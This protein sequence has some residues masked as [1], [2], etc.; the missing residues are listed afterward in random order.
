[1][2]AVVKLEKTIKRIRVIEQDFHK[3]SKRLKKS[4]HTIIVSLLSR[5]LYAA[6]HVGDAFVNIL[7]NLESLK[8]LALAR[9]LMPA[10]YVSLLPSKS[11]LQSLQG[12]KL[13][14]PSTPLGD[15]LFLLWD[16]L[17]C[18]GNQ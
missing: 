9:L 18:L 15:W 11:L 4:E 1:M 12:C 5:L 8:N 13:E 7:A 17:F 3:S 16:F 14:R 10:L 2:Q 6:Y